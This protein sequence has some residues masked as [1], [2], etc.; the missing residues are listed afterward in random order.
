MKIVQM[1]C[2]YLFLLAITN[3]CLFPLKSQLAII[4]VYVFELFILRVNP[5]PEDWKNPFAFGLHFRFL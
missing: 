4:I 2:G 5:H 3:I 1:I